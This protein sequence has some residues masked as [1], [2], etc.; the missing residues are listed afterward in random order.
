MAWK[1]NV[2]V[3]ANQTADSPEL[4]DALRERAAQGEAEFTL[5]LPPLPGARDEA[6]GRLDAIVDAWRE[7]GLD[8]SG[9]LGD[10]DPVVTVKEAWDPGRFDEVIVSTLP[11]GA[12][13]W[14]Q[15]DLPHR[16]E[17]ITGVA[18]RHVVGSAAIPEDTGPRPAPIRKPAPA[19]GLEHWLG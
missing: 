8:A 18:V 10:S 17:R 2:L 3:V 6:R 7:A 15:I 4:V 9:E 19:P 5:L 1:T 11:T 13:K 16:V 14:L 12:S